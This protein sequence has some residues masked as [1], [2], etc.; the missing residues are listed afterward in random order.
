MINYFDSDLIVKYIRY[1][2][3]S[4]QQTTP[5]SLQ[6]K[7]EKIKLHPKTKNRRNLSGSS[8]PIIIEARLITVACTI[9]TRFLGLKKTQR[10]YS[11]TFSIE[12][13]C[14]YAS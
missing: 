8:P 2:S 11:T 1:S 7:K 9:K 3:Q 14:V 4:T 6:K 13:Q 12:R 10:A 5:T